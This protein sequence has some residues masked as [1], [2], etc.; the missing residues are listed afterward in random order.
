M[1]VLL[2]WQVRLEYVWLVSIHAPNALQDQRSAQF[3]TNLMVL[4]ICTDQRASDRAL[5]ATML[6]RLLRGVKGA[7]L[8]AP[9]V[10]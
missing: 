4:G 7:Q 8:V 5:Q 3:V 6:T 9:L 10:R 1:D 2:V